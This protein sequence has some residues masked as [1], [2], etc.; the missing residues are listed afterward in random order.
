MAL[1]K[2]GDPLAVYFSD[3]LYSSSKT[4][5]EGLTL[6][7]SEKPEQARQELRRLVNARQDASDN[8]VRAEALRDAAFE[9]VARA[10]GILEK[11]V[12][13]V[14]ATAPAK[15][16]EWFELTPAKMNAAAEYK[17][18]EVFKPLVRKAKALPASSPL[19]A[20][21]KRLADLWDAYV[22]AAAKLGEAVDAEL[23]AD[24]AIQGQKVVCC[25]V[26]RELHGHIE[27]LFPDDRGRVESFFRKRAKTAGRRKAKT[28]V[29]APAG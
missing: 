23:A 28:P 12:A 19:K 27:T 7:L 3:L 21:A 9:A 4:A 1:L 6:S 2:P 20:E 13:H 25:T 11:A 17:R 22:K 15:Y 8:V 18:S 29:P 14:H 24:K 10:L 26:M 16:A 5:G